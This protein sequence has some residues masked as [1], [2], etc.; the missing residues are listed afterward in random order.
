MREA[1]V[2]GVPRFA[3]ALTAEAAVAT[4]SLVWTA[5][6]GRLYMV[7]IN[8]QGDFGANGNCTVGCRRESGARDSGC[9][10][11]GDPCGDGVKSLASSGVRWHRAP[12]MGSSDQ[13]NGL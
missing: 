4:W 5:E 7:C 1:V 13:S 3:Q 8:P 9:E 2:R 11:A 10:R 6:G 12:G